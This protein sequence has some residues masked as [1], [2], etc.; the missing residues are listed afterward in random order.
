LRRSTSGVLALRKCREASSAV[1]SSLA[2]AN[3]YAQNEAMRLGE[4]GAGNCTPELSI[5]P[6]TA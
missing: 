3:S 2:H 4:Q 5:T 1:L 6:V